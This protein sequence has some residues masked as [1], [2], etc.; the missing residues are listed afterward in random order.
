MIRPASFQYNIETATSNSFQSAPVDEPMEE[1]KHKAQRE[2]D[3]MV[4]TLELSGIE[5]M[6]V[7]DT[8]V[9]EKPDAVFPNN[10][11]ST[12]VE[13][14]LVTYPMTNRSRR[15]ERRSDIIAQLQSRYNFKERLQLERFEEKD[16]FLE[17]TGSM[18]L[19]RV[20]KL[21]F[22]CLGE[23]SNSSVLKLFCDKLDYKAI[24]F[25][26]FDAH[27]KAIYHTNVMMSIGENLAIVCLEAITNE[28]ERNLIKALLAQSGRRVVGISQSQMSR[29]AGN[30]LE[31]KNRQNENILIMS[32][33]AF[34]SLTV[35]QI[36]TISKFTGILP[37]NVPTIEHF[38]GGSVRCMMMEIF[39]PEV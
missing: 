4:D 22:C 25:R 20:N 26:A 33:S 3:Q 30:M 14:L 8:D 12:H 18:V 31:V 9:P 15:V 16:K 23:R 21:A 28:S 2:F 6:V 38:G 7:G 27:G 1:I 39:H 10:W 37:I 32:R 24:E 11:I 19:D 35:Y 34:E 5:V 29:F 17:G 13:G 36:N